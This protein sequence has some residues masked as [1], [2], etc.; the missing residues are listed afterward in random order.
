MTAGYEIDLPVSLHNIPKTILDLAGLPPR[1]DWVS[2]QSLF[3]ADRR[4]L[5]TTTGNGRPSPASS[6]RCRCA[7]RSRGTRTCAFPLPKRG[8]ACLRHRGRPRRDETWWRAHRWNS[9]RAELVKGALRLGLDLRGHEEPRRWRQRDDGGGWLGDPGGRAREHRLLGLWRG[10]ERSRGKG[11]RHRHAV[12]HGRPDEYVPALP[13]NV[14]RSA[15]PPWS[16]APR[17]TGRPE[18]SS[19]SFA[20]PD[21]RS[22]S[23]PRNGWRSTCAARPGIDVMIGP[24]HGAATFHGGAGQTTC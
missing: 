13:A 19:A 5:G 22:S 14:E 2:G 8:G 21:S 11:R 1:P 15:S 20:H 12:V 4:E 17:G 23:R 9:L 6:A 10:C 7:P 3:A 24:K 16:A 18:R